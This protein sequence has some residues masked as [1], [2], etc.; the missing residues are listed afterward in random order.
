VANFKLAYI[1]LGANLG[2]RAASL[3]R[4]LEMLVRTAAAS[5]VRVS[6][7][8]ESPPWG[9]A[10]AHPFLNA[11]A[12]LCW[13]GPPL[14]LLTQ[15]YR[16]EAALGRHPHADTPP[17]DGVQRYSDRVIDLDLLWFE[18]VACATPQ[19]TLP[20][21]RACQRAFVLL[22]WLELAP[23]LEL[24]GCPLSAWLA[25]LDP[26]EVAATKPV[27]EIELDA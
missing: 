21:P 20:H 14:T 15:C 6:R 19:L 25:E 27:D 17:P 5:G 23:K 8:Y 24:D 2:E 10:S 1:G 26:A 4:A 12:E 16:I 9:Y 3:R 7:A 11:V 22:P 13:D 18:G